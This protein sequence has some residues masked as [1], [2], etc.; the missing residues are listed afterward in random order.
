[1]LS[2]G[3]LGEIFVRKKTDVSRL[4]DFQSS[5]CFRQVPACLSELFGCYTGWCL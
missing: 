4:G 3:D 2:G 1:M 5:I